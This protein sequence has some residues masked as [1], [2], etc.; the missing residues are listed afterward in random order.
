MDCKNC[1][2]E[3]QEGARFCEYCG[4]EFSVNNGN[5]VEQAFAYCPKCGMTVVMGSNICS[6]CGYELK[7]NRSKGNNIVDIMIW[8]VI[9]LICG[10]G[11]CISS[12]YTIFNDI[13][14]YN[15][16]YG[17]VGYNYESPL[18]EHEMLIICILVVSIV[19]FII[20]CML[21]SKEE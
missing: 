4:E 1:G 9:L 20:G 15:D 6:A 12:I 14:D 16:Y 18:T 11:G 5:G 3:N 8:K 2:K 7:Q 17:F 13:E 21:Q 19:L 10:I